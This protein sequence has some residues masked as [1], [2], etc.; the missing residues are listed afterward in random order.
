V[1]QAE[2]S[3]PI[4]DGLAL[5]VRFAVEP[6]ETLALA[7]PSGAGKTSVL[8]AIAGLLRP[9]RGRVVCDGEPWLDT[10]SRID[11]PPERRGCGYLFQ[12]YALFPHLSAW[13]NV[14][15]GLPRADRRRERALELLET[16]GLGERADARPGALSGG[17]RQRVALARALARQPRALLLDEPLSALDTR[18]RGRASRELAAALRDAG[19]P[20][21]LVTHDFAEAALLG[22][23][24]AVLDAGRI[25]QDGSAR[26]LLAAPASA[27]VADLTGAVVL[28][29]EARSG[30]D[31]LTLVRLRGTQ[32]DVASTDSGRGEVAVSVHPWEIALGPAD[33]A[34]S[35][36]AQNH[37]EGA[38]STVTHVGNRVRVGVEAGQP[39]V[40][41][42]TE[43]AVRELD[44]RPGARVTATWKAAATRLLPL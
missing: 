13:R 44:L 20:A 32:A 21:L 14:A 17:E 38:I 3:G 23:R 12:E 41:E 25:V 15:Y 10:E 30:P 34:A 43:T 11:V 24:V 8:R 2:L 5:D 16:F 28:T 22:D 4:G 18:T 6:G 35:G 33:V 29:G 9:A 27:F 1:L 26:E 40:A 37:L 7:G 39:L 42:V 31:G 19:V 36:S